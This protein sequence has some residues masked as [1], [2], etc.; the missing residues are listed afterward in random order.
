MRYDGAQLKKCLVYKGKQ[1]NK[2]ENQRRAKRFTCEEPPLQLNGQPKMKRQTMNQKS[3][4]NTNDMPSCFPKKQQNGFHHHA[5]KI[6]QL[7]SFLEHRPTLI[8][9][10]IR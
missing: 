4:K 3:Q 10:S 9:K 2:W 5:K 6:W 1:S 8:A 7:N